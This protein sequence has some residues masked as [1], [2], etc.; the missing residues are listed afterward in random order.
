VSHVAVLASQSLVRAGLVSLLTSLEFEDVAE[1]ATLDDLMQRTSGDELPEM[2]LANLVPSAADVSGL[3]HAIE[4]WAPSIKVVFLSSYLDIN[5][6]SECFAHGASGYLLE[7]LS[8]EALQ[9]SLALVSAGEKVYP[10]GLASVLADRTKRVIDDT[11]CQIKSG[12]L[13]TRE[14][15]ILRLVADGRSNK[16]IATELNIAESTAKLHLRNILRKLNA[17]NR[18]QAA[19]WAVQSGVVGD[20]KL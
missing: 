10:S 7:E 1:A 17:S 14:I 4:A 19:L 12:D 3:M 15:G 9:K 2:L 18:T 5:L 6:L 8:A 20:A 16:V 11:L 13:S